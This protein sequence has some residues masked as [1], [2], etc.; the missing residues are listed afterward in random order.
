MPKICADKFRG[1]PPNILDFIIS[2]KKKKK[3]I[4]NAFKKIICFV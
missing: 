4:E 1:N 3:E 2:A